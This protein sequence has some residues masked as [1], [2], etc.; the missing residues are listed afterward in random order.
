MHACMYTYIMYTYI[1]TIW[2]LLI[3]IYIYPTYTVHLADHVSICLPML[4]HLCIRIRGYEPA[5]TWTPSFNWTEPLWEDLWVQTYIC[6]MFT[7]VTYFSLKSMKDRHIA[8]QPLQVQ[9][10]IRKTWDNHF[11]LTGWSIIQKTF[12]LNQRI[13]SNK[14]TT[15]MFAPNNSDHDRSEKFKTSAICPP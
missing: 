6:L 14:K 2:S 9:T 7:L 1:C 4:T 15:N 8:N 3:C 10:S 5:T 12:L 11:S 13:H